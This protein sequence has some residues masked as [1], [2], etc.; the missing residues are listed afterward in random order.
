MAFQ[1]LLALLLSLHFIHS[2]LLLIVVDVHIIARSRLAHTS[3]S[4]KPSYIHLFSQAYH[5]QFDLA[6]IRFFASV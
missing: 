1:L 3:D 6:A 4:V 2:I 5:F